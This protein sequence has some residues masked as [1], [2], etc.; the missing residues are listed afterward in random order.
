VLIVR[1]AHDATR[2]NE[3]ARFYTQLPNG[4]R[5][6]VILPYTAHSLATAT[7]AICS[8]TRCET[9]CRRRPRSGGL[10]RP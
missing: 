1:G 10:I 7:T 6:F 9:S 2:T 4:D 3:P 5:Q 8:G